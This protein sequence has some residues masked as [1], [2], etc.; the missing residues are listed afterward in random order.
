MVEYK[1]LDSTTKNL[2]TKFHFGIP[3]T[4]A[5]N[6]A[7]WHHR[8]NIFVELLIRQVIIYATISI[9]NTLILVDFL[10]HL[11]FQTCFDKVID[12]SR[13]RRTHCGEG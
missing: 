11:R 9:A 10:H 5:E 1:P 4:I 12:S 13:V 7:G 6:G 3:K 2:T 8:N